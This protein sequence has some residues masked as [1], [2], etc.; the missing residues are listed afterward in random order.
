MA[1]DNRNDSNAKRPDA[2]RDPI[3]GTPGAHPVGVGIG[4]AAGGAAA[5]AAAGAVAGPVGAV[6]G[7]VVGGLIG[8]LA[9]KG[10]AE[11]MNPTVEDAYW[12]EA[13]ADE[14]YYDQAY[15]YEDYAPAYRTGYEGAS[16][17]AAASSFTDAEPKLRD[18]YLRNR[19]ASALEW[20]TARSATRSAWDR[21]V[22]RDASDPGVVSN[23]PSTR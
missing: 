17:Y 18:D 5:G 4:T 21:V 14:P 16:R 22:E 9:G 8:G 12:R 11:S 19:G 7:A 10:V 6:A 3:T 1:V 15:A 2:N 20:D 13:H 23:P